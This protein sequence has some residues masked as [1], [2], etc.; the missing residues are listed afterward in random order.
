MSVPAPCS[1]VRPAAQSLDGFEQAILGQPY[2]ED[3]ADDL[4]VPYQ[5]TPVPD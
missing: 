1:S 5:A 4:G 3:T 2:M